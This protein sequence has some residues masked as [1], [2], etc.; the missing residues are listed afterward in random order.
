MA[1]G[2]LARQCIV[3][4]RERAEE[5]IVEKSA[6]EFEMDSLASQRPSLKLIFRDRVA[7]IPGVLAEILTRLRMLV[8]RHGARRQVR[9]GG[10]RGAAECCARRVV[11]APAFCLGQPSDQPIVGCRGGRGV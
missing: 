7:L 5:L 2:M 11:A 9:Y 10:P 1:V 4:A 8:A 6:A 3:A